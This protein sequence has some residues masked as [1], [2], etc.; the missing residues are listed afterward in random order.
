MSQSVFDGV[1]YYISETLPL[2]QRE[3]LGDVLNARGA[4]PAPSLSHPKLTHFITSSIALEDFVESLPEE[5]SAHVVTPRWVERSAVLAS[6]QDPEYY[7]ADPAYLFSGVTAAATDLS[8][9]DC[10]LISA[11]I[12][13][14]GGQWR[15]ALTR[16]VTHLFALAPGSAKYETALHFK[17]QTG[18]C[19]LVP[20]WFD[21]TVRLGIRDLPTRN[22]E[23]PEPRVFAQRP[24][25]RTSQEDAEY[26]PPPLNA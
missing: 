2:K 4:N 13:A 12:T 24:E 16:D 21:D 3:Q 7:S 9:A 11:A 6:L 1:C 5:T 15:S 22:Y 23:W 19:I 17:E 25:G 20:H 14:L 18:V 26:E 8:Q 10:E